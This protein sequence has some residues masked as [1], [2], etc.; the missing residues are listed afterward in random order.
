MR[1]RLEL[2]PGVLTQRLLRQLEAV[3]RPQERVLS[4]YLDVDPQRWGDIEGVR[5]AVK[6]AMQQLRDHIRTLEISNGE[7][8]R[9]LRE[10]ELLH[11]VAHLSAGRRGMRG[12]AGFVASQAEIAYA[13]P[14]PW[15]LRH[16][17]FLEE[18]F[19]LWPLRQAL[20]QS[21][22]MG[23]VL[24]DKDEAKLFLGYLG[25]VEE[26]TYIF[27][28][29]PPKIRIPDAFGELQFRRKHVEHFHHHFQ[30]VAYTALRLW[31]VE[32]FRYLIVGGLWEV[33][34]QFEGHLH[35][36]LR[37]LI[38]ARWEISVHVPLTELRERFQQ[39]EAQL[40]QR[41]AER[42]WQQLN[43]AAPSQQ[44]LGPEQV[45]R[46]LWQRRVWHLLVKPNTRYHGH[47]CTQCG[48]LHL[49]S[50]PCIECGGPVNHLPDI[51]EE[52]VR[53]ALT[54]S[55]HVR[56]WDNPALDDH[57]GIAALLRY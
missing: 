19:V 42:L 26:V 54:Q 27:D 31:E 37:D 15:P 13:F 32:P 56:Y 30:W 41:Q 40:L 24:V 6:N 22:P 1:E 57:D 43:D 5:I 16:Q 21:D 28:E 7:R 11:E 3:H 34:P 33:L 12:L 46:A 18:R 44:A 17:Y 51:Y 52:A 29:V 20:D 36:Y 10:T 38:V 53:E 14:L 8:Q 2:N 9:L 55:A 23:I 35:R 4:V 39:E 50:G 49:S 48:R 47:V 45:F 25:E